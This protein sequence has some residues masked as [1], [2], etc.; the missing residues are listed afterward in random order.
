ME[1]CKERGWWLTI[2]E[3]MGVEHFGIVG[4]LKFSCVDIFWHH[5]NCMNVFAIRINTMNF[6]G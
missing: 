6:R 1:I 5:P 2:L 3:A 4:G